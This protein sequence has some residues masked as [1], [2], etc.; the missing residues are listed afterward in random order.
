M[1]KITMTEEIFQ[2]QNQTLPYREFDL[3][4]FEED[5]L[6]I[7]DD[8]IV[9]NSG[10]R[11]EVN[12]YLKDFANKYLIYEYKFDGNSKPAKNNEIINKDYTDIIQYLLDN[13]IIRRIKPSKNLL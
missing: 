12:I 6:V 2:G 11:Y 7:V 4:Y 13:G 3:V 10:G 8:G 5:Y 9:G 1:K